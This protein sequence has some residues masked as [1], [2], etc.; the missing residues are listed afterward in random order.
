MIPPDYRG[1]LEALAVVR[2]LLVEQMI[3]GGSVEFL[4]R[5][6]LQQGFVVSRVCG[7]GDFLDFGIEVFEDEIF[8]RL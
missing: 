4:L 3:R 2:P 5:D 6:L 8:G 1:E 7:L